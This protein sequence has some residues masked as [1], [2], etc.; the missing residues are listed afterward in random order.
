MYIIDY[1][2]LDNLVK[3][4]ISEGM[5]SVEPMIGIMSKI[6]DEK[7]DNKKW[8]DRLRYQITNEIKTYMNQLL[9]HLKTYELDNNSIYKILCYHCRRLDLYEYTYNPIKDINVEINKE[10]KRDIKNKVIN[11]VLRVNITYNMGDI[12]NEKYK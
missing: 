4:T 3:R 11:T 1:D 8:N 7:Y 12:K 2:Y 5:Y 6:I 10:F 9:S